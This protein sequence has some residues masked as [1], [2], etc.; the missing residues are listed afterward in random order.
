MMVKS[1]F[2]IMKDVDR[3]PPE[4]I[5]GFKGIPAANIA[6]VMGRFRAMDHSIKSM[7]KLGTHLVG[8]AVTVRTTPTDNLMVHK[9]L[10]LANPGDVIVV[11]AFGG[12]ENALIGELMCHYAIVRKL[13]GFVLNA[14]I[15]DVDAIYDMDLPVFAK[16]G[17]PRGPY[18]EGPGE[19]NTAISCGTVPVNP[20]DVIVGDDDG[21]VVVP[22]EEAADVLEEAKAVQTK[23]E[24]IIA[25]MYDEGKWERAWV[26]ETLRKKGCRIID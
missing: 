25:K 14:P 4:V 21:V 9:A 15:R 24:Q 22:K 3:V 8:S 16:G 19:I 6:D 13:G 12:N 1:G 18:K 11:D 20:G 26:D 5:D 2:Q 17:T 23:E 10:D 7:N